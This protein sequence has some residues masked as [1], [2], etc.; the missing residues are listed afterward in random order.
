MS[1]PDKLQLVFERWKAS[2]RNR[3]KSTEHVVSNFD[4][5]FDD[6][7]KEGATF[8]EAHAILPTAIKAHQPAPSVIRSYWKLTKSRTKNFDTPEK[9][10][11]EKWC[12]DIADMA[13]NAFYNSFPI[14]T[15]PS[16][17]LPTSKIDDK[18][19][20]L[21]RRHADSFKPIDWATIPDVN[22][23]LMTDEEEIWRWLKERMKQ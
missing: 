21:M 19:Y 22:E 5:L 14:Q 9:E 7:S 13:T 20:K 18:E 15:Q 16:T 6:L 2:L 12:G 1:L 23:D 3:N 10:F 4:E 17:V 11:A 8:D